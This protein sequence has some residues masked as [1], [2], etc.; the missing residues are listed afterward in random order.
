MSTGLAGVLVKR[1]DSEMYAARVALA[2][3][4][5]FHLTP[6]LKL[7]DEK[8]I[9]GRPSHRLRVSPIGLS[10]ARIHLVICLERTLSFEFI[11][12]VTVLFH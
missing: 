6:P 8:R 7:H 5:F 2:A 4:S 11:Y 1:I 10:V 3:G 9:Y 12:H